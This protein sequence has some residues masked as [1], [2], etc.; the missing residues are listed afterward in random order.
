M[1][2]RQQQAGRY[3]ALTYETR[4]WRLECG[5]D[6]VAC[7]EDVWAPHDEHLGEEEDAAS[8]C[9]HCAISPVGVDMTTGGDRPD[10]L[11]G[12]GLVDC[13]KHNHADER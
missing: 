10:I 12:V 7:P 5:S 2:G 11:P 3:D 13:K 9:V 4:Q 1:P 8:Q 6:V